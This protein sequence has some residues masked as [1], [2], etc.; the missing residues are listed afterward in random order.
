MSMNAYAVRIEGDM[1][2]DRHLLATPSYV[3]VGD[4]PLEPGTES[5][6]LL[7]TAGS[8]IK[9]KD[10]YYLVAGG[11]Q[12]Q[13]CGWI[14]PLWEFNSQDPSSEDSERKVVASYHIGRV[15]SD[16]EVF[17]TR[18]I[19][20]DNE[21]YPGEETTIDHVCYLHDD[22]D[23]VSNY[24]DVVDY[25]RENYIQPGGFVGGMN[26]RV[27]RGDGT[28]IDGVLLDD[29]HT[30]YR[31]GGG[32]IGVFASCDMAKAV[33]RLV[34]PRDCGAW[35]QEID[36]YWCGQV[37]GYSGQRMWAICLDDR[38]YTEHLG[39]AIEPGKQF[40]RTE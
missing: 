24:L 19:E 16:S 8:L 21:I 5:K 2:P 40:L 6:G 32:E 27:Y 14:D 22:H 25:I 7:T 35:F 1:N 13:D 9:H 3:F 38:S 29:E 4:N 31:H 30:F 23:G 28:N 37:A 10:K 18:L 12:V 34:E 15:I 39:R 20:V 33:E 17:S 26:I 11:K 36:G